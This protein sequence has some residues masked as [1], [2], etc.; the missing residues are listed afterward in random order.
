MIDFLTLRKRRINGGIPVNG[1]QPEM[2]SW[3]GFNFKTHKLNATTR[4]G[5]AL[6]T[7]QREKTIP[8]IE[9]IESF[10]KR[11]TYSAYKL[12]VCSIKLIFTQN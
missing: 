3:P 1:C 8:K 5:F 6:F 12:I 4:K 9:P 2:S 10:I 7:R 11:I